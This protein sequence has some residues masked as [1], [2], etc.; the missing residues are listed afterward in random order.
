MNLT[1]HEAAPKL[2]GLDPPADAEMCS[3]PGASTISPDPSVLQ[4]WHFGIAF[5]WRCMSLHFIDVSAL[6]NVLDICFRICFAS[7]SHLD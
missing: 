1:L 5:L 4:L 2:L 3:L 7:F 6:F